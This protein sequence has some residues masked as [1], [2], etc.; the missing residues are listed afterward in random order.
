[1]P[2]EKAVSAIPVR[3]ERNRHGEAGVGAE[4]PKIRNPAYDREVGDE[5]FDDPLVEIAGRDCRRPDKEQTCPRNKRPVA[6]CFPTSVR[7]GAYFFLPGKV[8]LEFLG[9]DRLIAAV[10]A[11]TANYPNNAQ[12]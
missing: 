6:V 10:Q 8:A 2:D 7:G 1:M 4:N 5:I 3:G 11:K 9:S 12:I